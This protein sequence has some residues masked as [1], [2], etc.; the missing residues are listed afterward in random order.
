MTEPEILLEDLVVH[1]FFALDEPD[2]R[3]TYARVRALWNGWKGDFGHPIA[4]TDLPVAPPLKLPAVTDVAAQEIVIAAQESIAGDRQAVL[5]RH[6]EVLTVSVGFAARAYE[7]GPAGSRPTPASETGWA[8]LDREWD[9]LFGDVEDVLGENRLYLATV[10]ELARLGPAESIATAAARRLPAGSQEP[11]WWRSGTALNK[12]LA[13]WEISPQVAA[14]SRRRI[15]ALSPP[16]ED[17]GDELS[18]WAWSNGSAATP[19]F[20]RY[21]IQAAKLRRLVRDAGSAGSLSARVRDVVSRMRTRGSGPGE[22]ELRELTLDLLLATDLASGRRKDAEIVAA[23]MSRYALAMSTTNGGS[24][25][26]RDD[27]EVA[28]WLVLHL[29]DEIG[30][31]RADR[32]LLREASGY[33]SRPPASASRSGGRSTAVPAEPAQPAEPAETPALP[34]PD[35]LAK[36]FDSSVALALRAWAA[37]V[38]GDVVVPARRWKW[39]GPHTG[40]AVAPLLLRQPGK[41]QGVSGRHLIVKVCPADERYTEASNLRRAALESP[42]FAAKHLV[43]LAFDPWPVVDGRY[44][45][46]LESAGSSLENLLL[47]RVRPEHMPAACGDTMELILTE[48][49]DLS[50]AEIRAGTASEYLRIEL[51]EVL[52]DGGPVREWARRAGALAEDADW[53][54][55]DE[56]GAAPNPIRIADPGSPA[57]SVALDYLVGFSHGDLHPGNVLVT[58]GGKDRTK[59]IDLSAY[60]EDAPLTRDL[61]SLLLSQ[62]EPVVSTPLPEVSAVELMEFVLDPRGA[63]TLRVRPV[64]VDSVRAIYDVIDSVPGG[65]HVDWALQ[66][67]LSLQANSVVHISYDNMGPHGRWWFFRLA[68]RAARRFATEVGELGGVLQPPATAVRIQAPSQ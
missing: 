18:A 42:D 22:Q 26:F 21:L 9:E 3:L 61:V 11:W 67:L 50:A 56:S 66:Y 46:F 23:N 53:I 8:D 43:R 7:S 17:T 16:Q 64:V 19:P 39:D 24:G 32:D 13:V 20:A 28:D 36:Y 5:R 58:P 62:V 60:Q 10:P 55:V 25:L 38:A 34:P 63:G 27:R 41:G 14:R 44:L 49:N 54:V 37:A 29:A 57:G 68:A 30:E 65:L 31:L 33:T 52:A 6:H 1:T 47:G 48:W 12:G 45:L 2:G 51:R 40:A 59:L 4:G 35:E 15:V